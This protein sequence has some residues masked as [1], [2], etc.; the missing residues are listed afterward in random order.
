MPGNKVAVITGDIIAST[1]IADT[2]RTE[3]LACLKEAIMNARQFADDFAPEIFQGDS[4][5]GYT[6]K[7]AM[8]LRAGLYI[9]ME[10]IKNDFALRISIAAGTISFDSGE[11]LTS[12]GT[13]FRLSGRNL[14]LLKNTD[15][16][17]SVA[18]DNEDLNSEWTV[19]SA[20]LNHLVKRCTSLQAEAIVEMIKG[21]TQT[22][23]AGLLQIK[24][25]AVQ[26]RLQ[27]AGWPLVQ[28]ILD[29]F[30]SQF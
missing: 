12:D 29:R 7:P 10:M 5:Q 25:P 17:I 8:A 1:G 21:K 9:V 19:H 3:L 24:Q 22:E 2:K 11:S 14:E 28:T 26:Q 27:A 18:S 15:Q 23:I 16:V 4:F 20:T 30:E 13:A 6:K